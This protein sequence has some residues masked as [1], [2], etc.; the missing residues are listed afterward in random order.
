MTGSSRRH[1]ALKVVSRI[2][3]QLI[4]ILLLVAIEVGSRS[5]LL[6]EPAALLVRL[7]AVVRDG[8]WLALPA[9]SF[10]EHL[11]ALNVYFPGSIAIFLSVS[12]L[13]GHPSLA[14]R[15]VLGSVL[16]AVLA[17]QVNFCFGRYLSSAWMVASRRSRADLSE[18]RWRMAL[19]FLLAFWHPHFGALAMIFAAREK[20]PYAFATAL[21]IGATVVWQACWG[22]LAYN[23]GQ[24]LQSN[25]LGF[26]P[27][28]T[29]LVLWSAIDLWRL[30][31]EKRCAIA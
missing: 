1:E 4:L 16:G 19:P 8:G 11:A 26:W 25:A 30:A 12:S 5:G 6:P 28:L 14:V 29:C 3:T 15:A 31:R 13:T 24:A 17:H 10:F 23:A 27:L 9:I 22:F 7:S 2:R 18:S 21:S 20:T